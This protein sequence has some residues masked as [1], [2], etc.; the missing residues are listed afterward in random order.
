MRVMKMCCGVLGV[1]IVFLIAACQPTN[2]PARVIEVTAPG[3]MG[4]VVVT[5]TPRAALIPTLTR[6]VPTDTSAPPTA[7]LPPTATVDVSAQQLACETKLETTYVE[8][9]NVC[10]GKPGGFFCNGGGAPQVAPGGALQSALALPG[11][12]V[13][14]GEVEQ[15]LVPPM[16]D[17]AG[18]LLWMRLGGFIEMNALLVG[19]VRVRDITLDGFNLPAWQ[20][21]EVVTAPGSGGCATMPVST[22]LMQSKYGQTTR[23]GIN[24]LSMDLNGTVA[25]QTQGDVTSFISLEGISTL[26]WQSSPIALRAGDQIDVTYKANDFTAP[27]SV[28][29]QPRPL[30]EALVEHLPVV[31]LDRPIPVPQPGF[32]ITTENVNMRAE[33]KQEAFLIYTVPANTTGTILGRNEAGDWLHVRLGNGETG[34]MKRDL[35]N[36]DFT[37]VTRIYDITP[38]PPQRPGELGSYG[39]VI[40]QQGANLRQA[41]DVAFP[42]LM[43]IPAGT[44]VQLIGRSPYSPWVKIKT[45]TAQGWMALINIETQAVIGSLAVDY[46]VPLPPRA[47]STPSFS[48]GGGHA[49]PDPNGGS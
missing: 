46:Q 24:G 1:L 12:L 42:V 47:T 6:P 34:W 3:S 29:P 19:N 49:Y 17:E 13:E 10:L 20:S 8:A 35:L 33:P 27:Q 28:P 25:V 15:L 38:L 31:L 41:P 40:A 32:I 43:S 23:V 26:T 45:D 39:T 37:E 7:T 14:T 5:S 44:K 11:S 36:G 21:I 16:S 9:A 30:E 22:F 2:E 48:F 18:G 4:A